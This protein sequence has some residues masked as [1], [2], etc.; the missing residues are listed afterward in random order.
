MSDEPIIVTLH[1]EPQGKG[2]PRFRIVTPRGGKSFASVY[3]PRETRDYENALKLAGRVAMGRKPLLEGPIDVTVTAVMPVPKSWSIK[4]RDAALAGVV[5][6][7]VT[8]DWD[9]IAKMLDGLNDVVWI[10][11]KQI[12]RGSIVKRYGE[13]PLLEV[14]VLEIGA[15]E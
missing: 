3:T 1:G 7:I 10:D 2:R 14:R 15:F 9:N 8:P 13:A 11:D 4:K 6:P 12:V 5:W